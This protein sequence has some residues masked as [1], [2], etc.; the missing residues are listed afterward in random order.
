M[1]SLRQ[2][3]YFWV[4]VTFRRLTTTSRNSISVQCI[5]PLR[6]NRIE[7]LRLRVGGMTT[8]ANLNPFGLAFGYMAYG[9]RDKKWKYSLRDS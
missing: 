3:K 6:Q 1:P 8:K 7:G 2:L 9:M 4:A 5:H